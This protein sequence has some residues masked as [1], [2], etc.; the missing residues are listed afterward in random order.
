[1]LWRGDYFGCGLC[2]RSGESEEKPTMT[3]GSGQ[4]IVDSDDVDS[5]LLIFFQTLLFLTQQMD[6][7]GML[8]PLRDVAN[9]PIAK[10][11]ATSSGMLQ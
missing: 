10:S 9:A 2:E 5:E 8:L 7:L 1:M 11:K 3:V 6:N 4:G